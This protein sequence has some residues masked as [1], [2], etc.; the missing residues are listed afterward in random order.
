MEN[1]KELKGQE[2]FRGISLTDDYTITER[3]LI[4]EY[5]DK[6]KENNR[7]EPLNS[8]YIWRVRGSP[9]N[10]LRLK[11]FPKQAPVG[12]VQE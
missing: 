2:S 7:N 12:A 10:G 1:L 9:K 3:H 6:A 5:S 8:R 4:K 11:K